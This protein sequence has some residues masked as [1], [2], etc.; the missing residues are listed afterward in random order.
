VWPTT[1]RRLRREEELPR[2]AEADGVAVLA[3]GQW[4]QPRLGDAPPEPAQADSRLRVKRGGTLHAVKGAP[5]V[6]RQEEQLHVGGELVLARLSGHDDGEGKAAPAQ[7]RLNDGTPGQ[8]LVGAKSGETNRRSNHR[9]RMIERPFWSVKRGL[10][11]I[12]LS[13]PPALSF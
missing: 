9:D 1:F 2:A 5:G 4:L 6:L 12:D 13:S 7:R 10:A 3:G 8:A 11:A